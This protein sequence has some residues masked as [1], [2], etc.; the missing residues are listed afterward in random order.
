MTF[1]SKFF[2]KAEKILPFQNALANHFFYPNY[3]KSIPAN[4][5]KNCF[6]PKAQQADVSDEVLERIIKAYQLTIKNPA[7]KSEIYNVSN[8]WLFIYKF[9]MDEVMKALKSGDKTSLKKIYSNFMREKCSTGLHGL[10]IDMHDNFFAKN[11]PSSTHS[12]LYLNDCNYRFDLWKSSTG[13]TQ[14]VDALFMPEFG[15]SYG[16]NKEGTYIRTGAE[17]LHYYANSIKNLLHTKDNSKKTILEIGGGY[18]GLAYFL[19][20]NITNLTYVDLDLPENM[21]LTAYYLLCSFPNKKI[22]LYGEDSLENISNYDIVILPNFCLD[23]LKNN[24]ADLVFNSYSLAEMAPKTIEHYMS[25]IKQISKEFIFHI[26][27]SNRSTS[28]NAD[29]FG[30]ETDSS[31]SLIYRAKA[32]WNMYRNF[33]CDEYEYLYKKMI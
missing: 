3:Q 4:D 18:G 28:I 23:E 32:M 1:I 15:N 22:M 27:H 14:N 2:K 7:S 25:K 20:K 16:Y 33:R 21:A 30:F 26:N 6:T 19:N 13:I 11:T 9:Y 29:N 31:Y 12:K 17:Y 24:T 10:A 5:I 8:E